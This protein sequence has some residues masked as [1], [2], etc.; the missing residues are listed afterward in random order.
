MAISSKTI[1]KR[2]FDAP[3]EHR[4]FPLGGSDVVTIGGYT[5]GLARFEPGWKWSESLRPIAG[6]ESC[7][8]EHVGYV[9]SGRLYTRMDDG[10]EA[11]AVAGDLVYVPPGH[12]GWTVG[13][14]PV[15]FLQIEGAAR[16]AKTQ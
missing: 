14:E 6:T 16:Y 1:T 8:V 15:L 7:Q 4:S 2:R 3:D 10:S 12:D 9:L 5:L 13:D 11:E